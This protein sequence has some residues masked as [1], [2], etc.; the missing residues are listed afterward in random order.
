MA[1]AN[2]KEPTPTKSDGITVTA[3]KRVLKP[4]LEPAATTVS[5]ITLKAGECLVTTTDKQGATHEFVTSARMW[6]RVYSKKENFKLK[7]K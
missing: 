3:D 4:V 2:K 5:T 7:K 6:D 1:R